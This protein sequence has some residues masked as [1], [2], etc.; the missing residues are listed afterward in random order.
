M[1]NS[2]VV[3]G[4]CRLVVRAP[5]TGFELAVPTD[6]PVID[7]LPTI[8]GYAGTDLDEAGLEHAGW[9]LQRLGG[10]ALDDEGTADSL[11]L[12]DGDVLYLRPRRAEMPPIHFDDLVDGV[13]TALR[14]RPDSWRPE[15]SRRLLIGFVLALLGAGL[16]VLALPGAHAPRV[17]AAVFVAV[18]LVAG[19]ASAARAV[20]DTAAGTAL[21]VAAVP[22]MSLAAALLPTGAGDDL[23]GARVLAGAAATTGMAVIAI[24]V[25]GSGAPLFLGVALASST[26]A[27]GGV[28]MVFGVE[29]GHAAAVIA[30][31]TVI[32]GVFVPAVGFRLS[33]LKLPPLPGNSEQLQEGIEP[34]AAE[35]VLSRSAITDQY[36]AA[37]FI[38]IAALYVGCLTGL[39]T[40]GGW[41]SYALMGSLSLLALLHGRS[42]GGTT[43]RLAVTLPGAYG[44]VLVAVRLGIA[45]PDGTRL[46]LTAALLLLAGGL[47]IASWS[48]PGRRMLPHWGHAADLVHTLVAVSVLPLVLLVFGAYYRLRGI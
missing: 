31:L 15:L 16:A 18:L 35:N 4:L 13:A 37:L 33:G 24:A 17:A 2:S 26:A 10:A 32:E 27:L 7:L 46:V 36:V 14:E 8:V 28:A 6:V 12:H 21:G 48:V 5:S 45:L 9:V 25:V 22:F 41:P 3:G 44:V 34:L 43:Q 20:G 11:G 19:A 1:A 39:T 23:L 29:L 47:A 42:I 38:A 40:T 30:A